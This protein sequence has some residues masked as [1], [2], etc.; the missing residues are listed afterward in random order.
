MRNSKFGLRNE[1]PGW[2]GWPQTCRDGREHGGWHR[3]HRG[4]AKA[5]LQI[6]FGRNCRSFVLIFAVASPVCRV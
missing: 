3:F 1:P 2:T 6:M 4:D 5:R